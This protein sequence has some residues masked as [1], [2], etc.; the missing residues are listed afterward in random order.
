MV[1]AYFA[2]AVLVLAVIAGH[3]QEKNASRI[4]VSRTL[5]PVPIPIKL[6]ASL[7]SKVPPIVGR[8][9]VNLW[10]FSFNVDFWKVCEWRKVQDQP[11][12]LLQP[13]GWDTESKPAAIALS[14]ATVSDDSPKPAVTT[15]RGKT[16]GWRKTKSCMLEGYNSHVSTEITKIVERAFVNMLT[17][18]VCMYVYI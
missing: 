10:A 6:S 2:V 1:H 16:A 5:V 13:N 11:R 9:H 17:A 12:G 7:D 8:V 4:Y 3:K 14:D 18:V 15:R